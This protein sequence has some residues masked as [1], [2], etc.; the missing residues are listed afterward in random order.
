MAGHMTPKAN[1]N[2]VTMLD[3]GL[4]ERGHTY[5]RDADDAIIFVQL[6]TETVMIVEHIPANYPAWHMRT[7]KLT[8]RDVADKVNNYEGWQ[9]MKNNTGYDLN[10]DSL[11]IVYEV[12]N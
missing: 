3:E 2:L 12:E 11:G 4:C 7:M 9:V 6:D 1:E 5:I 8:Q 10:T